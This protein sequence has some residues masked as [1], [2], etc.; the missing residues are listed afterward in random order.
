MNIVQLKDDFFYIESF[1]NEEECK[2][3]ISYLEWQVDNKILDWNQI[4]FYG[5]MAMG[6][7]PYDENLKMFNLEKDYFNSLKE[8]IQNVSEKEIGKKLSEVSYHAQKW[9]E[10]AFA[11]YHSDNS[12]E[13]GNPTAFE[14][15]KYAAFLYLNDNF[16]GGNLKFKNFD[17]NL[18][19]KT[20]LIA[21]F[22]GEHGNEHMVTTVSNGTRY[23]VGS[24]WDNADAE[25]S[26]EKRKQW[27]DELKS[28]R[29]KQSEEYKDWE[30]RKKIGKEPKLEEL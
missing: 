1:I 29:E 6:Y 2:S 7:W 26:D 17:I 21:I 22:A 25:Y 18:K 14:R 24:F 8:K 20:G 3:I 9:V 30:K 5:S 13:E 11:G 27:E 16:D 4:S 19:P 23:T 28:V 10:G 12:D 15:S